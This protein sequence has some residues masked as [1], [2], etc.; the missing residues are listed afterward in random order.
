VLDDAPVALETRH[1]L[2]VSGIVGIKGQRDA[3][4]AFAIVVS[5]YTAVL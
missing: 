4:F 5:M 2:A 1:S 3:L